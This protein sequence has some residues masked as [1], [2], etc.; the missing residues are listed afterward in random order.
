MNEFDEIMHKAT[1]S[2][3]ADYLKNS[4]PNDVTEI[5]INGQD[6]FHLLTK[7]E[8]IIRSKVNQNDA[9]ILI[10]EVN[11]CVFR[12]ENLAFQQGVR[13]GAKLLKELLQ[14]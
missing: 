8:D 13:A 7:L 9:E 14:I 12:I 1:L 5:I 10:K 6:S 11:N 3:I 4:D 2:Q